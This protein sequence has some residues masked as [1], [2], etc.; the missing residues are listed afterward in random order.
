MI[1]S[2]RLKKLANALPKNKQG[3]MNALIAQVESMEMWSTLQKPILEQ[4]ES[5][6]LHPDEFDRWLKRGR[7]LTGVW[8]LGEFRVRIS[9]GESDS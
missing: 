3:E 6:G 7:G 8:D 1:T 2:Q 9:M 4:A 5:M